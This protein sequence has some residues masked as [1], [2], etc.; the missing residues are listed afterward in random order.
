MKRR[1]VSIP[2]TIIALLFL[3]FLAVLFGGPITEGMSN[4]SVKFL[5]TPVSGFPVFGKKVY[6]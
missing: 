4:K 5:D 2:T 6:Q 1:Q 3:L